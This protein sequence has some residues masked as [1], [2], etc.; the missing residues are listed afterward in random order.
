[1]VTKKL[2]VM[3][4]EYLVRNLDSYPELKAL[5][6]I[7]QPERWHPEGDA[8]EHTY[9]VVDVWENNFK[10]DFM[11]M[12]ACI[13][14]DMGKARTDPENWPKHYG[15]E[16]LG[17]APA[18]RFLHRLGMP[19]EV[20]KGVLYLVRYHMH[21][22]KVKI[23]NP[24]TFVKMYMEAYEIAGEHPKG[25][26]QIMKTLARLGVC[27]HFGRGGVDHSIAYSDADVF[28]EIM[29]EFGNVDITSLSE[30]NRINTSKEIVE[31]IRNEKFKESD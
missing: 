9:L 29:T 1:M 15:H 7:P 31:R 3:N 19:E 14:H 28:V 23:L 26:L 2:P 20:I 5:S 16:T 12:L 24:K 13:T 21:I 11:L 18:R 17:L 10:Q 27:D 4:R 8:L 6:G 22:H 25:T 30:K